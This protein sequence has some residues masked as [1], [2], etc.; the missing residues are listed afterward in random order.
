[1][2]AAAPSPRRDRTAVRP[3]RPTFGDRLLTVAAVA[4]SVCLLLV[5]LAWAGG[6][7]MVMFRTG[8]M[9]P[10][11]PTGSLAI[12]REVPSADL[13]VGDVVTVDRPG[14][15]PVT[16][17]VVDVEA[18][19]PVTLTL[20]GDANPAP[21]AETYQVETVRR[22][23][24]SVPELGRVVAQLQQPYVLGMTAVVVAGCVTWWLWPREEK[25]EEVR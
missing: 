24:W 17:R 23:L 2:T 19:T 11:I 18:T 20:Q 14:R 10:A 6:I 1:M 4:G 22:V 3:A 8:S 7:T 13:A 16:H 15:L 5:A 25:N 21:D 12:V 9:S